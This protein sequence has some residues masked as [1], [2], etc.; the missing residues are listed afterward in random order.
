MNFPAIKAQY[1][2]LSRIGEIGYPPPKFGHPVEVDLDEEGVSALRQKGIH[3]DGHQG[4]GNR[5]IYDNSI[6]SVNLHVHL[7]NTKNN[8]ILLEAAHSLHGQINFQGDG[9]VAIVCQGWYNLK[10]DFVD[11]GSALY[12]GPGSSVGDAYCW[13]QGTGRSM[14]IGEDCMLAWGVGLRT[15]D[16]HGVIDIATQKISNHSQNMAIG[17][18]VWLA[19]DVLVFKGVEIG[20]GTAVS[21]RSVVTRNLPANCA[22]GGIPAKPLK[23]GVTWC[24]PALPD[25]QHIQQLLKRPYMTSV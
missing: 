9:H 1:A 13:V 24:R 3:V 25:Q 21:S 14:L 17:P 6:K 23:T 10:I 22:A 15:G 4:G 19:Q 18:H 16:A 20:A 2:A 7:H 8:L 12:I 5:L 11:A